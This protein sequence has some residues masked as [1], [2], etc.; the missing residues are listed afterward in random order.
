MKRNNIKSAK[1]FT[2]V[3]MLGVL[4]IIAILVSI[5]SVGVMTAIKS[6]RVTGT[7]ANLKNYETALA[8]HITLNEGNGFIPITKGAIKKRAAA[9]LT[10][11]NLHLGQVLLASGAFESLP[12]WR[13]GR[14][15]KNAA[16]TV[17]AAWDIEKG[18]F[19]DNGGSATTLINW[20]DRI[21]AEAVTA[22]DQD[23]ATAVINDTAGTASFAL[24]V[25]VPTGATIAYVKIPGV[26]IS[27][28]VKLSEAL[29]RG[30]NT[31]TVSSPSQIVGRFVFSAGTTTDDG[32]G[33]V[34]AGQIG[35]G[36]SYAGTVDCY[37][38]LGNF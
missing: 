20:T 21:R 34:T 29:N 18:E 28:A 23:P 12:T 37:Y 33:P 24:P 36:S 8:A 1:G 6:A 16:Q 11:N 15:S 9:T 22:L 17:N 7:I 4:A 2:L 14:E 13:I 27:D 10:Q 25:T 3:E 5:V 31:A 19:W 35:T 32:S 30:S 26:S 38:Y